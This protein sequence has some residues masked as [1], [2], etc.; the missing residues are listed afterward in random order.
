MK[1]IEALVVRSSCA[2]C[3]V[4]VLIL[5][6]EGVGVRPSHSA[7]V[8]KWLGERVSEKLAVSEKVEIKWQN[9]FLLEDKE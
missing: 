2:S 6:L 3:D 8:L 9:I 7:E 1:E 4:D 5:N